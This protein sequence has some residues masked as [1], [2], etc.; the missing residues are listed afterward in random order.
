[1]ATTQVRKMVIGDRVFGPDGVQFGDVLNPDYGGGRFVASLADGHYTQFHEHYAWDDDLGGWRRVVVEAGDSLYGYPVFGGPILPNQPIDFAAPSWGTSN[2]N[3]LADLQTA[4]Q[5][6]LGTAGTQG[7]LPRGKVKDAWGEILRRS[8]EDTVATAA[9]FAR[10]L[11]LLSLTPQERAFVQAAL[12]PDAP[13]D[14][15]AVLADYLEEQG[16]PVHARFREGEAVRAERQA[17]YHAVRDRMPT[18]LGAERRRGL[19]EALAAIERRQLQE[20][21]PST[22]DLYNQQPEATPS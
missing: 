11:A 12:E 3:P 2:S 16:R 15:F 13:G 7:L 22:S 8:P 1:M 5:A 19:D 21:T 18:A 17:C 4:Q 14:L 20:A 6:I 9:Q 10:L